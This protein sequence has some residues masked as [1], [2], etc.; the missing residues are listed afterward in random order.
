MNVINLGDLGDG[1]KGKASNLGDLREPAVTGGAELSAKEKLII[2]VMEEMECTREAA[3]EI[4]GGEE[5]EEEEELEVVQVVLIPTASDKKTLFSTI[6]DDTTIEPL[7]TKLRSIMDGQLNTTRLVAERGKVNTGNFS[8]GIFRQRDI[9]DRAHTIYAVDTDEPAISDFLCVASFQFMGFDFH[10][11]TFESWLSSIDRV[12]FSGNTYAV[13]FGP[14][15]FVMNEE[16]FAKYKSA[17]KIYGTVTHYIFY[18]NRTIVVGFA[19]E[20]KEPPTRRL[21]I[22]L[23]DKGAYLGHLHP[24]YDIKPMGIQFCN[25]C[26][27]IFEGAHLQE[28]ERNKLKKAELIKLRK[29]R[30]AQA[31]TR[32]KREAEPGEWVEVRDK[33][34][35]G[36]VQLR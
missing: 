16:K 3:V 24:I 35:L 31:E 21:K 25:F 26:P 23:I 29:K 12:K 4:V 28:C 5:E 13:R 1:T 7:E 10:G 14:F 20:G 2:Q 8:L 30:V 15:P 34:A 22:S 33:R 11:A 6:F 17:F 19:L 27:A 18:A 9:N 32:A 36:R